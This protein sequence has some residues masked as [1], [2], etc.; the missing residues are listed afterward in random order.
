LP[1]SDSSLCG[2]PCAAMPLLTTARAASDVSPSAT[3]EAIARREWSSMSWKI[4]HCDRRTARTR[5]RRAANTRSGR[6]RRI[7]ARPSGA[8]S[9]V[10]P[11]HALL[12][13]DPGQRGHRGHRRHAKGEHLVVDAD[14]TVVQPRGLERGPTP[15]ACCLTSSVIW[16]GDDLG[17]GARLQRRGLALGSGAGQDRVERLAGDLMLG[18]EAGHR[19]HAAHRPATAR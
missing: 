9:S 8:S 7:C 11:G 12:P 2:T 3:W 13:E 14:R 6:G 15:S 19:P 17:P 4:T 5:W 10:Q 18:T 1:L 16:F